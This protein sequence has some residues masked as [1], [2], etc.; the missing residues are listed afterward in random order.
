MCPSLQPQPTP[1][2]NSH[3]SG[4]CPRFRSERSRSSER[5]YLA[6][7]VLLRVS[8][9]LIDH[10]TLVGR[11]VLCRRL[12]APHRSTP[13]NAKNGGLTRVECWR[14]STA[15][16]RVLRV[17]LTP[18]GEVSWSLKCADCGPAAEYLARERITARRGAQ[19]RRGNTRR[20]IHGRKTPTEARRRVCALRKASAQGLAHWSQSSLS[21]TNKAPGRDRDHSPVT[22][23]SA[24][25]LAARCLEY[26]RLDAGQ[27]RGST[28][29]D[30]AMLTYRRKGTYFQRRVLA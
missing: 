23:P 17:Q 9:K 6:H 28:S 29:L 3:P 25:G 20:D 5:C 2:S 10:E 15:R 7:G 13:S 8:P 26:I 22:N 27:W 14:R 24:R 12:D 4:E 11:N 30:A 18:N 1:L 16:S 21:T 19:D